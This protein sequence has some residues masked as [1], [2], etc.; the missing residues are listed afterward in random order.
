[1]LILFLFLLGSVSFHF[2]H[3][4]DHAS[5]ISRQ[6]AVLAERQREEEIVERNNRERMDAMADE[7]VQNRNIA[8]GRCA[9][10]AAL[11]SLRWKHMPYFANHKQTKTSEATSTVQYVK[12]NDIY[13]LKTK[14]E[15]SEV[16]LVEKVRFMQI[17]FHSL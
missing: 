9:E 2:G 17:W 8:E 4:G 10:A 1:M 3:L 7:V 12:E 13:N 14:L 15:E 16:A 5:T 6:Q 11:V